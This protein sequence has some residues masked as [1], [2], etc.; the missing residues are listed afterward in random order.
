MDTKIKKV[1]IRPSV[2]QKSKPPRD[3]SFEL[4]RI[5]AMFLIIMHHYSV[6]GGFDTSIGSMS[7]NLLLI[8]YLSLGGK[9]GVN[10]FIMI[11]GYFMVTSKLTLKK[12]LKLWLEIFFYSSA[13]YIGFC[14]FGA[15]KFSAGQLIRVLLPINYSQYWFATTYIILILFS[16]F[17]NI[18]INRLSQKQ[19]LGLITMSFMLWV[20]PYTF[21]FGRI[22]NENSNLI[23]FIFIYITAAYI[24]LYPSRLT[25]SFKINLITSLIVVTLLL[26]WTAGWDYA[27]VKFS[28]FRN[29][30]NSVF[31]RDINSLLCFILSMST[32]LTFKNQRIKSRFVNTI[33]ASMFGVYLIHDNSLVRYYLWND[34][35]ANSK[36]QGS[37]FLYMHA[38]VTVC[39]V[40][41][42]CILIDQIRVHLL[43]K[44]L[45]RAVGNTVDRLEE[46][47]KKCINT[48]FGHIINMS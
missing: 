39:T 32:F 15:E 20:L 35:F 45:F 2:L 41:L 4:L 38:I 31:M 16:P 23:W 26:L 11:C 27:A 13:I 28:Y 9:L 48:I 36:W 6:H 25:S 33:S 8:Q 18:L 46:K 34:L 37:Q 44:P 40:F 3:S 42:V 29:H 19:H 22:A 5:F 7:L 17:I 21:S 12:I 1:V 24:R 30:N 47:S 10:L 14:I 43:E